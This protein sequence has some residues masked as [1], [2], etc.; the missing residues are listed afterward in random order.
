MRT[1][2]GRRKYKLGRGKQKLRKGK[3]K[4]GRKKQS[5]RET[6]RRKKIKMETTQL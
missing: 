5:W 1:K 3:E 4:R 2:L 6:E